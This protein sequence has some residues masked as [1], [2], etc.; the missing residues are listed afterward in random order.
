MV[1]GLRALESALLPWR[2]LCC[3]DAGHAPF[4]LCGPCADALPRL[5]RACP[6]CAAPTPTADDCAHCVAAPP[7]FDAAVIPF[8]YAHPVDRLIVGLKFA[9]RL[10]H[11]RLLGDLL[12][13]HAARALPTAA[14]PSALVPVPLHPARLRAR[15]YD[16][17][18]ELA[19]PLAMALGCP[20][21][22]N[23]RR[24]RATAEQSGLDAAARRANLADAFRAEGPLPPH[25]AIVDDVVTTGATAAALAHA[26]RAAGATR[27]TLLAVARAV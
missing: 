22:A 11:A 20:V 23:A 2:C 5:G 7:P 15:G 21:L 16:Q 26:L 14:R 25:V 4:D 19:R 13:A 9:G 27:I 10:A 8:E 18:R 17:A 6:R 3:G 24:V 1:Y 12:A